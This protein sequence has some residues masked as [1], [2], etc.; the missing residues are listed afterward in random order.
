[1]GIHIQK[2]LPAGDEEWD[3]IWKSCDYAVYAQSR[4]WAEIWSDYTKG[5]VYPAP[6][7][8]HFSDGKTALVPFSI[9]NFAGG[10]LKKH[11]LSP[12][13]CFGGWLSDDPL[14]EAH[15]EL[16]TA[17]LLKKVGNLLW[18]VN[19][20]Q[21]ISTLGEIA[22]NRKPYETQVLNLTQGFEPIHKKWKKGAI[23]RKARKAEKAGV[24]IRTAS[25]AAEWKEFFGVYEDTLRRWGDSTGMRYDYKM[26][27][28][29][30]SKNSPNIRLRIAVYENKII[31]GNILFYAKRHVEYA[32]GAA[33]QEY[34]E[35]RPVNLLMCECIKDCCEKGYSWFDFGS[36]FDFATN[37]VAEG[38]LN[39]K[40]SFGAEEVPWYLIN[41]ESFPLKAVGLLQKKVQKIISKN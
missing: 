16:L 29:V 17:Y 31:A 23:A 24:E 6:Q 21:K 15:D 36:S 41:I 39:F 8:I 14:S 22:G 19:P 30:L 4:E 25:S 2:I 33:L 7:F 13:F 11:V 38:V 20:F 26:T 1:M 28:I 32:F 34:F 5:M 37:Q 40:K 18:L 9:R 10:L 3:R 35:L 12:A 27:D